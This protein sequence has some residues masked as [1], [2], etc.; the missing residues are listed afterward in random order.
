MA[1]PSPAC[2]GVSGSLG[3]TGSHDLPL[4][5][6]GLGSAAAG[7]NSLLRGCHI[8]RFLRLLLRLLYS[9]VQIP[10]A[11]VHWLAVVL[12]FMFGIRMSYQAAFWQEVW[13]DHLS[14]PPSMSPFSSPRYPIAVQ[15]EVSE[16]DEVE[17]ELKER[18]L[19]KLPEPSPAK[20]PQDRAEVIKV[21]LSCSCQGA[22]PLQP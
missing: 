1:R 11:I 9:N 15:P 16:L 6:P 13:P 4:Y 17:A 7:I 5:G 8:L 18:K 14:P 22:A 21:G 20:A 2:P 10:D 19:M 3:G 12:F